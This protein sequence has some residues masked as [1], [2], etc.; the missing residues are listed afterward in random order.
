MKVL[1]VHPEQQ[2]S[3]RL[4]SSIAKCGCLDAYITTVY[5]KSGSMTKKIIPLL[6]G[7][8]KEKAKQRRSNEIPD[9]KVIIIG[10]F[11][12]LLNL[13]SQHC[14]KSK[15]V[16]LFFSDINRFYFQWR[17]ANIAIKR[18]V[19]VII[20]Y[21]TNVS[22]MYSILQKKA[23]TIIRITDMAA[24]NPLYMQKIYLKD[25]ELSPKVAKRLS[26]EVGYFF[27]KKI[28]KRTKME[29][30]LSQYFF[31]PS[32]FVKD[33]LIYSGISSDRIKIVPYGVDI[34]K[35]TTK[36]QYSIADPLKFIY[37]G[38]TK[39]LKGIYYLLEAFEKIPKS[40]ATLIV[41]GN[42]NLGED[43]QGYNNVTYTG[44]VLHSDIPSILNNADVFIF[45][46]LGDSFS[47]SA[48]EGAACGLPLLIST[49]TGMKDLLTTGVEGFIF[50][51]QSVNDIVKNVQWFIDNP[52][53]VEQMGKAARVMAEKNTWERYAVLIKDAISG[54]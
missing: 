3:Y 12:G 51:V 18:E 32:S 35:F 17:V 15:R 8:S 16:K 39:E 24:A 30:S 37:V 1:V 31:V 2:H 19:D 42:A 22:I 27:E 53:Y 44:M 46:S 23:P 54:L 5:N 50:E 10:E 13:L 38:G 4:A 34:S 26:E 7:M 9:E 47:L 33:S 41:V 14:F 11:F 20:G 45:P 21:N 48:M 43:L 40:K 25:M 52:H 6:R 49:N 36:V 28:E 29:L